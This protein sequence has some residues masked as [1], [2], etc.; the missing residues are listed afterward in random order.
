M[1]VDDVRIH[2][3]CRVCNFIPRDLSIHSSLN[4]LGTLSI[5]V[6]PPV[7]FYIILHFTVP[8]IYTNLTVNFTVIDTSMFIYMCVY[9]C[10]CLCV[11]VCVLYV[12][13]CVCVC[14]VC[15]LF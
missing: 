5:F 2:L 9:I 1:V 10:I 4:V 6:F 8:S 11:C 7:K 14:I 13:M 12:F 15:V 3:L